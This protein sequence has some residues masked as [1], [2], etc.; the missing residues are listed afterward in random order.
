MIIIMKIMK[1]YVNNEMI[2]ILIIWIMWIII[3]IIIM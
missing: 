1:W 3:L 2:I